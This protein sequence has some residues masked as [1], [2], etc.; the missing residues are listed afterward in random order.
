MNSED[1][2]IYLHDENT[3]LKKNIDRTASQECKK[4]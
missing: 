2:R 4:E 3:T 1:E